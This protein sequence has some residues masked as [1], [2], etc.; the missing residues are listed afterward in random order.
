MAKIEEVIIIKRPVDRV[1]AYTTDIK[2]W[3]KWF[4]IITEAE[5]TSPGAFGVGTTFKVTFHMMGM[6]SRQT[7]KVTQYEVNKKYSK[8]VAT[9]TQVNYTYEQVQE[10]TK[11]TIVFNIKITGFF[12]LFSSMLLG[13]MQ[14][15]IK[16]SLT[17]LK[18][19]LEAQS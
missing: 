19:I 14:K 13:S 16:K 11:L 2:S 8:D 5:Q 12:K 6:N 4:V 7:G 1:F 18:S 10:G 3:P 9:T 15:D 17:N